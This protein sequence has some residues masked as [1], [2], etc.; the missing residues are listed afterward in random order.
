LTLGGIPI[1]ASPVCE[2]GMYTPCNLLEGAGLDCTHI[3]LQNNPTNMGCRSL[4]NQ[5]LL[6]N[7]PNGFC[8]DDTSSGTNHRNP[9]PTP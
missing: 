4:D 2:S 9:L 7:D 6:F 3:G 8:L 1:A 5:M